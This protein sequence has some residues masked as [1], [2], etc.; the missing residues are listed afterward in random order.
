LNWVEYLVLLTLS[1]LITDRFTIW[2]DR[3]LSG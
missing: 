2:L 3:F 1:T